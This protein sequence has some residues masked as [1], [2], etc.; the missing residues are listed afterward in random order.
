[1]EFAMHKYCV[2]ERW[3]AESLLTL[4]CGAG[5]YHL[6]RALRLLPETETRLEGDRPQLGFGLLRCP[7]SGV[8]FRVIFESIGHAERPLPPPA[9]PGA[10]HR[11]QGAR[12]HRNER[13]R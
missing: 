5:H 12:A 10:A 8:V 3:A 4:Q 6:T 7:V 13:D 11:P 2:V 1:M 9:M